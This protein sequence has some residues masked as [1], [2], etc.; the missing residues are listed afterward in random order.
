MVPSALVLFPDVKVFAPRARWVGGDVAVSS[1][2]KA[3]G[4]AVTDSHVLVFVMVLAF[5]GVFLQGVRP[6]A[7]SAPDLVR[8]YLASLRSRL[9]AKEVAMVADD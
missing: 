5:G 8:S 2:V 7:L 1:A 4:V 9:M 3:E 6:S